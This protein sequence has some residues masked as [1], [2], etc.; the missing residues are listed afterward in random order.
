MR[1]PYLECGKIINIHGFRGAVKLES[2]CDSPNILAGLPALYFS[3]GHG[4]FFSRK[5]KTAS[6]FRQF[7][8]AELEGIADEDSA[9]RLRGV[10]TYAKREDLPLPSGSFFIAELIGTPVV[11]AGTGEKIGVLT[12]VTTGVGSDLYTVKLE[13]G[14]EVLIPAVP[15]FVVEV[16]PDEAVK[17]HTI[18]GLLGEDADNDAV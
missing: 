5:V 13:S 18:P 16:N 1:K 3:D 11:N 4:G 17:I 15:A 9:N 2:Y 6:V 7:V 14:K 12:D 10:T 8:I